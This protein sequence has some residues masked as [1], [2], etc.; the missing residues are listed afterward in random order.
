VRLADPSRLMHLR[1]SESGRA[2]SLGAATTSAAMGGTRDA[3]S[4][5]ISCPGLTQSRPWPARHIATEHFASM[6]Q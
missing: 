1:T 3:A 2:E 4:A 5:S 6:V